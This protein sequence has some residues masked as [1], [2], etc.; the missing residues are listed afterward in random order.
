MRNSDFPFGQSRAHAPAWLCQLVREPPPSKSRTCFQLTSC[1][2]STLRFDI[3]L[4]NPVYL[5][6]K[7]QVS[8]VNQRE[9]SFPE[10]KLRW[11]GTQVGRQINRQIDR[12]IKYLAFGGKYFQSQRQPKSDLTMFTLLE[13]GEPGPQ[14]RSLNTK[15][16]HFPIYHPAFGPYLDCV[17]ITDGYTKNIKQ[18]KTT[19]KQKLCELGKS[20]YVIEPKFTSVHIDTQQGNITAGSNSSENLHGSKI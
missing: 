10:W 8:L 13:A 19:N 12:Q 15:H 11:I 18:N 3:V 7:E 6:I 4:G 16:M 20:K 17:Y 5:D 1:L 14:Y 2:N 9:E